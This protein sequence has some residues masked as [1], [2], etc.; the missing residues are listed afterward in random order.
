[1]LGAHAEERAMEE[2]PIALPEHLEPARV[3]ALL[4]S[5]GSS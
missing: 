5:T 4:I 2:T 1:L 3:A